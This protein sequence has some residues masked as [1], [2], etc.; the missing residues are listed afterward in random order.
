MKM[1]VISVFKPYLK[2]ED[3]LALQEKE[4]ELPQGVQRRTPEQIEAI[5]SHGQNILV[6]ASAGS[7]KT[8]VMVER[9]V[10][11]IMRGV[12]VDQLFISTFTVK[13]A[14][15][16]KERLE[17]KLQN[18][19][20]STDDQA[21][22]AHLTLQLSQIQTADI[23]TMDAFTQ[24]LVTRYGYLLGISPRFSILQDETEQVMLK[25]K[26][27]DDLFER[28]RTSSHHQ[29]IFNDLVKNLT[30]RAKSNRAF[31]DVVYQLYAFLQATDDPQKWLRDVFINRSAYEARSYYPKN[32]LET[33]AGDLEQ[34]RLYYQTV[35]SQLKVALGQRQM[36]L[37]YEILTQIAFKATVLGAKSDYVEA[38]TLLERY[39]NIA[40]DPS[41]VSAD[42]LLAIE[43]NIEALLNRPPSLTKAGKLDK[44]SSQVQTL[45]GQKVSLLKL[46]H[47]GE[48]TKFV[49]L[50]DQIG[51]AATHLKTY[52]LDHF[53]NHYRFSDL[54]EDDIIPSDITV[55][56]RQLDALF[57]QIDTCLQEML[58]DVS[59][60]SPEDF[61]TQFVSLE[62]TLHQHFDRFFTK[63]EWE[64]QFPNIQSFQRL[65]AMISIIYDEQPKAIPLL[66][67]LV[68]FLGDFSEHYFAL[69]VQEA[70]L[71]FSDIAHVAI[72]I[73]EE[74]DTVRQAFQE[75]Y[76]EVMVD[77]YQDN[78][79]IQERLME[80]LA[81]G[82]NRF[83]VGDVKQSI[84]R[85]RQAD[86]MIFLDKF[87]LYQSDPQAGK[88][89]VLKENFRSHQE[90]VSSVNMVFSHLMDPDL[91]E[92]HY[93]AS[94]ELVAGDPKKQVA[95]P[96]HKTRFLIYDSSQDA[97]E[98][99]TNSEDTPE[100][101]LSAGQIDLVI[102]EIMALKAA[103]ADFDFSSVALLVP[104]RTR[105]T[106]ILKRFSEAGIPLVADDGVMNYL[107]STEVMI[108]LET[109]RTI[110]N[111]LN[112]YAL[113]SLLKSPMFAFD[114][115]DLARIAVQNQ[116]NRMSDF[117]QK[118]LQAHQKTGDH[119]ELISAGLFQ[120]LDQF[121]NCL[122]SWRDYARTHLIHELIWKIY[123]E[124]FY[125]DYVGALPN[126]LQRQANL[127]S[128]ALRAHHY[129]QNG[130][131][132]LT[133]FIA[134]I[135]HIL[136]HDHDLA[137]VVVAL[138]KNAVRLM[139]IHKSKGLEFDYVFVLNLDQKFNLKEVSHT[140]AIAH[141]K[142]GVGMLYQ[143]DLT[144]DERLTQ[145]S[146][147]PLKV[148]IETL[149]FQTNRDLILKA[150][151]SEEMRL[152]YVA[153][154]RAVKQLY[155]VGT[156]QKTDHISS[157]DYQE[158]VLP[159]GLREKGRS[160]QDWLLS[161]YKAYPQAFSQVIDVV[162]DT[163]AVPQMS[164][165]TTLDLE[166]LRS[167]RQSED[168]VKALDNLKQVQAYNDLHAAGIEL[169]SLRTPS[170]LKKAKLFDQ[171]SVE[172]AAVSSASTEKVL[173]DFQLPDFAADRPLSSAE[174]GS[175]LHHLMQR[176]DLTQRVT[177]NRI[178]QALHQMT[179]RR[180]ILDK[181][182]VRKIEAFFETH[183]GQELLTHREQ[184]HRE[185]PFAMLTDDVAS[186]ESFVI[187]GIIDG[188]LLLGDSA[189][190][191]DYK[192]DKYQDKEVIVDRYR[193]QMALYEQALKQA[194]SIKT[195]ETYL[196]LFGGERL[197]VVL[198][199]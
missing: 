29:T 196:I 174:L 160:F 35:L 152:L 10:D 188:Y 153:M 80:L 91:G 104:S 24:K 82:Y 182:P 116:K 175:A 187:R 44:V 3:V 134:K 105:N 181:M 93:D 106:S 137:D 186:G 68:A 133:R 112:D 36:G 110:N 197:E 178:L 199:D 127:Y 95:S 90:V 96:E 155:L 45:A 144:N 195:I 6:S 20:A 71:E 163:V 76:V 64:R 168:I 125:L 43:A 13:A 180:D 51:F 149:P 171:E 146:G 119:P 150:S 140:K 121:L 1:E 143:A 23:G 42:T 120:K 162:Y 77:E 54:T 131:R 47:Q 99:V 98:D 41:Q 61:E 5:Y 17:N 63:K 190:L 161:L 132:G 115:D 66:E 179:D 74:H 185:A 34:A 101:E 94:Q 154:T 59:Q 166:D 49:D 177:A 21:L 130:Y 124:R 40:V 169:P 136:E 84:Y 176:L 39:K 56:E 107:K 16:L 157:S 75:Q 33:V 8:F 22:Q 55:I 31:R 18:V 60:V 92:I 193:D 183:L 52:Q 145:L 78:S 11:M 111:P 142:Q 198:V 113:V 86:P 38:M 122:N 128:L 129:E 170:Q 165:E 53:L 88:L 138:P 65:Y 89:I 32:A 167:N 9:I 173:P 97:Q 2:P 50:F 48:M 57:G 30:G 192:T 126:G 7:G 194:Y 151:L 62:E 117:Y 172:L 14:T 108:M 25:D 12:N 79:P 28:Y 114:E 147:L 103:D 83:M 69:K 123:N 72:R 135:D 141:P 109:L 37:A 156:A 102:R 46:L 15:E 159:L 70:S 67:V 158:L 19:L 100:T 164:E 26:V 85:F 139:T 191:F 87:T 58:D 27:F 73:L 148:S 81:N 118:V 189:I 184:L 4:Q